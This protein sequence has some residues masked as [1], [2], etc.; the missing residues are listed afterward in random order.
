MEKFLRNIADLSLHTWPLQSVGVHAN[1]TYK[2]KDVE[3]THIFWQKL[4]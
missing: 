2:Q 3:K 4:D 1:L